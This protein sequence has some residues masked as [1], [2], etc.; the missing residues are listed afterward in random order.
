MYKDKHYI[1]N[2]LLMVWKTEP[3]NAKWKP[4]M[5]LTCSTTLLMSL[6]LP[7]ESDF[8]LIKPKER[9]YYVSNVTAAFPSHYAAAVLHKF[10][11][12]ILSAELLSFTE[13]TFESFD[14]Y[15]H[16]ASYSPSAQGHPLLGHHLTSPHRVW[17]LPSSLCQLQHFSR[18]FFL[19]GGRGGTVFN[20]KKRLGLFKFLASKVTSSLT[21]FVP[22]AQYH[23]FGCINSHRFNP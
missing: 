23:V 21:S 6:R 4:P 16:I 5:V 20:R 14:M 8:K 18:D 19:Y 3:T 1:L 11:S 15:T 22:L 17:L 12:A 10:G 2:L 7:E 9:G 13:R